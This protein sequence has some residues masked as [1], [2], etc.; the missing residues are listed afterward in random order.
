MVYGFSPYGAMGSLVRVEVD[1]R[2]GIPTTEIVG[3]AGHEVREAR[4]RVRA[5]IRNSGFEYPSERV[6]VNLSPAEIPKRGAGFDLPVALA[7]LIAGGQVRHDG[8]VLAFGELSVAGLVQP[9]RGT[10]SATIAAGERGVA[11]CLVPARQ[12]G[13]L[14]GLLADLP[15][16]Y[17]IDRLQDL[18]HGMERC[19]S[20]RH[21]GAPERGK[22]FDEM[23]GQA[24]IKWASTISAA[25]FHNLLFMG[26]PGSGKTMA[27]QRIVTLVGD[28]TRKER[29]ETAR[30]Y[31]LRGEPRPDGADRPP[32]RMPHH[33]ASLEG[34]IGGGRFVVPGEA[35]L[36]H[37]GVL[38]LDEATEFRPRVIQ[39]LREPVE[40]GQIAIHRA[41]AIERFPARF[42][43]VLT[44]NLCPCGKLGQPGRTC[45]CSL[46]DVE[47]YWR[48]LGAALLDRVELRVRTWYRRDGERS[49][50]QVELRDLVAVAADRQR[51]RWGE[52]RWNG[53]LTDGVARSHIVFPAKLDRLFRELLEK[54]GLSDRAA[55]GVRTVAR[56]IADLDDREN[57]RE[58]DLREAFALHGEI[59]ALRQ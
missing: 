50:S 48:R 33:S 3:L 58:E 46:Q 36:A 18:V 44:S 53:T 32:L 26:P 29:L 49:K 24:L 31:S 40:N 34:V 10:L 43:L 51:H 22:S 47:R 25:G 35:S 57:L 38:L 2:R 16:V 11:R 56:T 13:A 52:S 15:P 41:G 6:L 45:M 27:A 54:R 17:G 39:G 55:D 5:A 59:D 9:A 20:S 23:H 19:S 7:I 21:R 28:L 12:I 30:I 1:L 42:R 8:D 14:S 37:R 4:D